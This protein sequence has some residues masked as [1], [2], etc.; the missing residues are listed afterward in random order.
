MRWLLSLFMLF[1]IAFP[2]SLEELLQSAVEKNP[3]LL[4]KRY[5]V[6]ASRWNLK[7]DRQLYMPE[8][9]FNYKLTYQSEKQSFQLPAFGAFP[10]A[11]FESSKQSYKSLQAGIRQLLFDGGGRSAKV[12]LSRS[13]LFISEKD[14]E[15][16]LLELKLEVINAYLDLLSAQELLEVSKKR[17][18]ALQ[19]ELYQREAFF[20]EGLVAIT[21]VLQARVRLAQ[22]QREL[23]EAEGNYRIALSN[24]SRLTGIEEEKLKD[25][26]KIQVEPKVESLEELILKALQKRPILKL[27]AQRIRLSE[28][29]RKAELSNMYPKAFVEALYNYSDQNPVV[30]PK[31]FFTLSGGIS[32][33]FQGLSSYYKA[34]SH[35]EEEKKA[36]EELKDLQD[37]LRLAIKKAYENYL[38]AK[39]NLKVAEENLR[40]A[41]E[42]YRLSKEQ[43]KNQIISGTDLLQAEAELTQARKAR[44]I[45]YYELLKAYYRLL[46]ERGEL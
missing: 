11:R 8:I 2:L 21:D 19:S 27:Y 36:R 5:A 3:Q 30:S 23:R 15:E 6:E 1:E 24:L 29:Q 40:F 39:D 17:V 31:G 32:W 37:K 26:K 38:T 45:A 28:V 34:L 46:R 18:E 10:P 9:L 35:V 33:S 7:A 4:S 20:K 42:Y 14:Y 22:A 13:L 41:E 43:Y 16:S 12:E 25:L 44:I